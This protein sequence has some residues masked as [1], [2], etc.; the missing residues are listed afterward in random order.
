MEKIKELLE[1][2]L[3]NYEEKIIKANNEMFKK[4]K[5][6]LINLISGNT[7]LT[8]QRLNAFSRD[9]SDRKESIQF[10]QDG[11]HKENAFN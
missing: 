7:T 6:S 10:M 3:K 1:E 11:I 2:I 8:N 4:H 9:I 5:A